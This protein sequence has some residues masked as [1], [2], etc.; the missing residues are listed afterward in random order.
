[1]TIN[2]LKKIEYIYQKKLYL[3][4]FLFLIFVIMSSL[5]YGYVHLHKIA[6]YFNDNN[7]IILSK[8]PFGYGPLIDNLYYNNKY[9]QKWFY[10]EVFEGVQSYLVR[11]PLLP[12][13][14][15]A[16]SKISLNFYIFIVLKNLIFLSLFF[17]V[18]HYSVKSLNNNYIN[19]L[20]LLFIIFYN[21]YNFI[22]ILNF[23]YSDA[24]IAILLPSI[25]LILI[26]NI[27]KKS[28]LI[29]IFLFFL[30]FTKTTM[31]F[32][33]IT[34]S[35]LFFFLN[36][37]INI[38]KRLLPISSILIAI[39]IW[40]SFG[41]IKTGKFPFV[42]GMVSNNQEALSIVMN[43]EFHNYYPKL[44]VDLIPK[45]KIK[46]KF[47]SEWEYYEHYKKINSE[48]ITKNKERIFKDI[49]IKIKFI[50]FNYRKDQVSPDENGNYENP[51]MISHIVNRMVFIAS[52]FF[53]FK[54]LLINTKTFKF[55]NIDLY[56]FFII[57]FSLIPHVIGW[58]S[59]KH[60]VP[61]FLISHI[62]LF[63]RMNFL[64]NQ[65]N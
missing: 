13:L 39:L 46:E 47:S 44:S 49:L 57:C 30:F 56:Y 38:I 19:F 28:I 14:I 24:I 36:K 58:A 6:Y 16:I 33:T 45:I 53:L 25:F 17:F 11:L 51:I 12:L 42:S 1:M 32:L 10:D 8:I 40:G 31:F 48:Y 20:A 9:E 52:L 61:I 29:S 59:S 37:K 2:L 5:V 54:N 26:S 50:L 35:I 34:I 64:K 7:Q 22:V 62:Y 65:N 15:V 63:F 41:Y 43:K 21:Y 55:K 4:Y 27:K 60:L 18:S 3:I 23:V